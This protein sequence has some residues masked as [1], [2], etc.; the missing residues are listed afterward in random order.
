LADDPDDENAL[1]DTTIEAIN[2]AAEALKKG[3]S[4]NQ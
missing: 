3:G 4:T 2:A 1:I